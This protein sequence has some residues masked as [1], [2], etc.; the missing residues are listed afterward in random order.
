[1]TAQEIR[2]KAFEKA[3]FGG[4]DMGAVD[5][6]MEDTAAE[7]D[8]LQKENATLK[9]KIKVLV[10]KIEEY[11]GSEDAMRL[12][13]L[14]A[15]KFAAQ[16]EDEARVRAE[17][18]IANADNTAARSLD[19][20]KGETA[21]EQQKLMEAKTATVRFFEEA[22]S[23][24]NRQLDYLD[25]I[26]AAAPKRAEAGIDDAVRSIENS[27][28]RI[29]DEPAPEIDISPAMRAAHR[30]DAPGIDVTRLFSTSGD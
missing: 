30:E 19:A 24:C 1:M 25:R 26:T 13:L 10:E 8:V 29:S 16:I 20:L 5:D 11:R 21:R 4:Y 18:T 3:V 6:F 28:A 22:R 17:K 23:I 14:S 7:V 12:T 15:Q 2:E 9:S 27:V